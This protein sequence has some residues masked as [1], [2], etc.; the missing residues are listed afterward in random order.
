MEPT[1]PF[2][3]VW[4]LL[5][6]TYAT[7]NN[8]IKSNVQSTKI[9]LNEYRPI[10]VGCTAIDSQEL[11]VRVNQEIEKCR[12]TDTHSFGTWKKHCN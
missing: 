6:Y 2:G 7:E 12:G 11:V 5:V 3:A 9:I 8:R 1:P 4:T 10:L